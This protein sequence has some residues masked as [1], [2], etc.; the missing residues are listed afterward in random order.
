M[1]ALNKAEQ[2]KRQ[3]QVAEGETSAPAAEASTALKLEL[4]PLMI[5]DAPPAP[6]P[7]AGPPALPELPTHLG[8]LDEEF[9][10][11]AATK[12]AGK[13]KPPPRSVP[14]VPPPAAT[15]AAPA[16]TTTTV[17]AKATAA[18]TQKADGQDRQAAQNLFD[19][20]QPRTPFLNKRRALALG[21]LTLVVAAAI[22]VYFWLQLQPSGG[23][24]PAKPMATLPRPPLQPTPPPVQAVA[25][26]A[27]V[28]P[29]ASAVPPAQASEAV[30][31]AVAAPARNE[32]ASPIRIS[33]AKPTLNPS[34]ANG[35]EA[36][37]AGNFDL[38]KSEYLQVLKSE[39][40]SLDALHGMAAVSLRQGQY[41]T[42]EEYYLRAIEADPKDALAQAGLIGLRGQLDPFQAETR[43]NALL[44]VQPEL[45]SIN[46]AL[47][48]LYA[49]QNRWNEAQ[50]AF[51]KAY[52]GE[53]DNPDTLFN[54]AVSLDQLHQSRLALQFYNLALAAAANRPAGFD[55]AQVNARL[56]ELLP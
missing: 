34:L 27:P 15:P 55:K 48:S 30:R 42:A 54:L 24:G 29:A 36:Y 41:A 16:K 37:I 28:A 39:P 1:D 47:G 7:E 8:V 13:E 21:L 51:F 53:P 6:P 11:H 26:P 17:A 10:A 52:K 14:A 43:L 40:S 38:A 50:A 18:A 31:Q 23:L 19:A 2:A 45:P 4:T 25:P 46:F 49:S 9:I 44:A 5:N 22:G 35:Y 3:S 32:P 20:K 12:Q 33:T 56:R